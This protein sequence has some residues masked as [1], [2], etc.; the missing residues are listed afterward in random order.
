MGTKTIQEDL[1]SLGFTLAKTEMGKEI[2]ESPER[3]DEIE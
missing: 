1:Q 2:S 3:V